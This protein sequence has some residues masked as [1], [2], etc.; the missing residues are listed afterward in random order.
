VQFEDLA[1]SPFYAAGDP[2]TRAIVDI[3]GGHTTLSVPLVRDDEVLG[4]ITAVRREV[5]PFSERQIALLKNFAGQAVVAMENAQLINA[6]RE[7]LEQQTATA[8]VLG[9]I[10]AHPGDLAPV[11]EALMDRATRLCEAAF[12]D[13]W[14]CGCSRPSSAAHPRR[15][16]KRLVGLATACAGVAI[17]WLV[18]R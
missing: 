17:V 6:T 1:A 13:L 12:G 18:R 15:Q 16:Q 14:I 2:L 8:E 7:A 4:V 9:V 5:R 10:N 3:D 11:F